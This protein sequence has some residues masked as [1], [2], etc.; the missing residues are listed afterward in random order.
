[1][2]RLRACLGRS[3]S[4]VTVAREV[5]LWLHLSLELQMFLELD[6][7]C[8]LFGPCNMVCAYSGWAQCSIKN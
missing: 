5:D 3:S 2:Q 8:M 4:L 6:R 1:M 7:C